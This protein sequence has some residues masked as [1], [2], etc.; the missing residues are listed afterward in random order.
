LAPGPAD[1]NARQVEVEVEVEVEHSAA[2]IL[3]AMLFA[4]RL[5][6]SMRGAGD[7]L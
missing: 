2:L 1:V 7:Q 4:C 5:A 3:A 6:F